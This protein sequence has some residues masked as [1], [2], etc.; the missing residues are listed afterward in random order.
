MIYVLSPDT[1]IKKG[2][3]VSYINISIYVSNYFGLIQLLGVG[4]FGLG[5]LCKFCACNYVN[6]VSYLSEQRNCCTS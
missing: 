2:H 5:L 6:S 1:N 4:V 3:N